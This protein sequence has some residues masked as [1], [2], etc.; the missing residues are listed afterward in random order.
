MIIN[1]KERI[2]KEIELKVGKTSHVFSWQEWLKMSSDFL[3]VNSKYRT[4]LLSQ[5]KGRYYVIIGQ[6][7][8]P[9]Y[10]AY[11]NV[12]NW[13]SYIDSMIRN[14]GEDIWK[15]SF[16]Y[17][18]DTQDEKLIEAFVKKSEKDADLDDNLKKY[19]GL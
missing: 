12:N 10:K 13:L 15:Y 4:N 9:I 2:G 19:M 6:E 8:Y 18:C 16:I 3:E 5:Q 7:N 17:V 14:H 1:I 11:N